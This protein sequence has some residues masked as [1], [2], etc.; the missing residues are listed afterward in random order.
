[1]WTTLLPNGNKS[2]LSFVTDILKLYVFH[3][4]LY[5]NMQPVRIALNYTVLQKWMHAQIK[6]S[7][8]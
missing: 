4:R 6:L 5:E 7:L 2:L 8:A 3:S 1:M